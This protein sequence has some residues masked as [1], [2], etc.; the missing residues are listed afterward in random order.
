MFAHLFKSEFLPCGVQ[1]FLLLRPSLPSALRH[2]PLDLLA[3][4]VRSRPSASVSFTAYRTLKSAS[5]AFTCYVFPA[6]ATPVSCCSLL[7]RSHLPLDLLASLVRS[8]LS[9][10]VSF[11]AYRTLKSS[12][13]T[14]Y[15][16]P[17]PATPVSCC[18]LLPCSSR[19]LHAFQA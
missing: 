16:F 9:A 12:A 5:S 7:P 3:S 14:C 19:R 8:R 10:S 1:L 13:F 11:T 18:S 4:L 2:L 15:V 6:A 17:A